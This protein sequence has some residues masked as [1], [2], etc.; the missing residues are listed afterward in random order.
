MT[1]HRIL[2]ATAL[3]FFVGYAGWE[4]ARG[5]TGTGA[6]LRAA[7]AGIGATALGL[8]FRTLVRR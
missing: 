1:A 7:L 4:L 3:A 6:V 2:I 8:Y 5:G